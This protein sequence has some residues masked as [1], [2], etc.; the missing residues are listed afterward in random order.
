M[1]RVNRIASHITAEETASP[2]GLNQ[3]G[4]KNDNDAVIVCAYRTP[5]C[6]NKKGMLKDCLP[7]DML[8]HLFKGICQKT[9]LDPKHIEDA[10]IGN[11]L[12]GGAGEVQVK[13]GQFMAGYPISCAGMALNRQCSSGLQAIANVT[14]AIQAGHMECGIAGGVESM[15]NNSMT[16]IV[17]PNKLSAGIFTN[18]PAADCLIPM[19]ITSENVAARF[20]ISREKQD[21]LALASHQ[22]A[23]KAQKEGLFDEEIIP[24]TVTVKDKKAGTEK[25][26]TVTADEGPRAGLTAAALA[27]LGPAFKKGGT[28]TAGNSSQTTDGAAMV[29]LMSRKKA[30]A[31]KMPILGKMLSF[32]AV[33]CDPFVMGI[34]P[35]VAIPA[36]L[37]QAGLK[38]SDI[39]IF[40][41]NEAF[42]SQAVYSIEKLGIPMEK[43][44]PKGG[45][46]SLGHP[47]GA[48]G[49]RLCATLYPELKRQNKSLGVISMCIGT[50]MGAAGVFERE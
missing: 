28:T 11:S 30:K 6:K 47:L 35:A 27:K 2:S 39:D 17:D 15:T 14:A 4:K 1:H 24:M 48:T 12:Q 8:A 3:R 23:L 13:L 49:A 19:G 10:Q 26:V 21:A 38:I 29:L 33:G 44:N 36:A 41:V 5:L 7:E 18:P 16:E 40:E 25:T 50:G 31:L 37:K 20:N 42:A 32:S 22:K 46:I 43:V 34:G 45:A 9:G